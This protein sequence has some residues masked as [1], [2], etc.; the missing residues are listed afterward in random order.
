MKEY[1][2][3]SDV[4]KI[5]GV[6][7]SKASDIIKKLR[8]KFEKEYTDAIPIQARIP[9]WYFNEKMGL[10][11]KNVKGKKNEKNIN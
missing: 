7:N 4:M 3:V 8:E 9:I 10:K 5:A 1:Y 2:N 11:N 6:G